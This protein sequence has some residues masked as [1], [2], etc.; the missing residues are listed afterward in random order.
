MRQK[1]E[2]MEEGERDGE[3]GSKDGNQWGC[4]DG[5][6]VVDGGQP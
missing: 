4:G 1:Q 5:E 6:V 2:R 3:M